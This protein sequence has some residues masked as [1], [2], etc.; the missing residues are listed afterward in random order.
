MVLEQGEGPER[1]LLES[2]PTRPCPFPCVVKGSD[3]EEMMQLVFMHFHMD[4]EP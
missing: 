2:P 3:K 4:G 1:A